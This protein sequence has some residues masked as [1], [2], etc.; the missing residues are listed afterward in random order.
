[1]GFYDDDFS[2]S[3]SSFSFDTQSSNT[4][5]SKK[6]K[7]ENETV[8]MIISLIATAFVLVFTIVLVCSTVYFTS[9]T[10]N[11]VVT[12]F[13]SPKT[14]LNA[15][16]HF[17]VPFIQKVEKVDMSSR[18]MSIGYTVEDDQT[19]A[20]EATMITH[21]FNF[22]DVFFYLEYQIEDAQKFLYNSEQPEL[23]LSNLAQSAIRD[24]VGS[25]GVDDVLTV[26]R[27]EIEEKV[28]E[29]LIKSLEVADIGITVKNATIQDVDTPTPEVQAA[30]DSVESAK[31]NAEDAVNKANT[32][33]EEQIPKAQGEADGLIKDA[34]ANK[35][36]RIEE[37]NGQVKRFESLY[38]EY[39]NA[40]EATKLRMYYEV[41]E[42]VMPKVK[43]VITNDDGT[44]VNVYDQ[45]T[46]AT[47]SNA[48]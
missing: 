41:M 39:K 37:A 32:Y 40:P 16:I 42:K 12:T 31:Q 20:T 5:D 7:K 44:I 34:E 25:Y 6:K 43:V 1:M 35:A 18:G 2:S 48:G 15:G 38:E 46:K 17:K 45:T 11:A 3:R 21:D 47:T 36:S 24:T 23:I 26:S 27:G 13:G 19:V 28:K 22:L 9:D 33:K 14:I 4:G 10:Q 30:F 8:S 29:T